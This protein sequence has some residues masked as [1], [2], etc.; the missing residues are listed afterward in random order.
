MYASQGTSTVP[1]LTVLYLL[2]VANIILILMKLRFIFFEN[3]LLLV[4]SYQY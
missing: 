3:H 2:K 4:D 1:V